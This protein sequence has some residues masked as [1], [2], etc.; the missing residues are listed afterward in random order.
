MRHLSK[1]YSIRI[2][3]YHKN[4][5]MAPQEMK[6]LHSKEKWQSERWP[7]EWGDYALDGDYYVEY[8]KNCKMQTPQNL[9]IN[10][11]HNCIIVVIFIDIP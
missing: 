6:D 8:M 5:L 11:C 10:K 4:W 2:G 3:S 9:L 1:E 7:A